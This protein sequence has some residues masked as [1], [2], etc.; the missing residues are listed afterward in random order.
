MKWIGCPVFT[1]QRMER[2]D[3][4]LHLSLLP[5][6]DFSRSLQCFWSKK[7]AV[8]FFFKL[9]VA[10]WNNFGDSSLHRC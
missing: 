9:L 1:E 8:Y 6:S 5:V 4:C 10:C 2:A 7:R 3:A